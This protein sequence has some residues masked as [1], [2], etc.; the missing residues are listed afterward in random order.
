M[1]TFNLKDKQTGKTVTVEGQTMPNDQQQET[2]FQQAG[3]RKGKALG[4][5]IP[6]IFGGVGAVGGGVA[7]AFVPVA[8]ETGASEV[9]G[10]MAGGALFQ[11]IGDIVQHM[12]DN[13]EVKPLEVAGETAKGGLYGAVP[14]GIEDN[15][16]LRLLSRFGIGA[17]TTTG[18]SLIDDMMKGK[19]VNPEEALNTL[20][21]TGT[22]GGALN[23]LAPEGMSKL[24]NLVFGKADALEKQLVRSFVSSEHAD[25]P[26]IAKSLDFNSWKNTVANLK[27]KMEDTYKPLQEALSK[28]T[29][30]LGE[31]LNGVQESLHRTS[32]KQDVIERNMSEMVKQIG[33]QGSGELKRLAD[34]YIRLDK[35]VT[36]YP[37]SS[38]AV[39]ARARNVFANK[40]NLI[41][42]MKELDV[43]L[44]LLNEAKKSLGESGIYNDAQGA[45]AFA[46]QFI[47][48][49]AVGVDVQGMNKMYNDIKTVSD[50]IEKRF[51]SSTR[52]VMTGEPY[53]WTFRAGLTS[54][55]AAVTNMLGLSGH[56]AA[57]IS[58]IPLGLY[59][60][61]EFLTQYPSKAEKY[62]QG[63][64]GVEQ[65]A[66]TLTA[67]I[68]DR[69]SEP[70]SKAIQGVFG[71][72]EDQPVGGE[73]TPKPGAYE[74]SSF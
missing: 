31:F 17:M 27:G 4:G 28:Q 41:E 48:N 69:L 55:L 33:R 29:G 70:I 20:L 24:S 42:R 47:E 71:K 35:M 37:M 52:D 68:M 62:I 44:N 56:P 8:G 15:L 6:D 26:T 67:Q 64:R 74:G 11:G 53:S 25:N 10:A 46:R 51:G 22:T 18:A 34:E 5:I 21:S 59:F 72:K 1:P 43:P 50:Q 2:I 49:K 63:V 19:T 54:A 7:G 38:G 61:R 16:V 36:K 40:Q 65:T 23:A 57:L 13:T 45:Y 9:G 60:L 73:P 3:L 30:N 32:L 66:P 58:N 12:L 14:G 39:G